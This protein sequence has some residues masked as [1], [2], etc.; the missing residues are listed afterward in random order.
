MAEGYIPVSQSEDSRINL[1]ETDLVNRDPKS[2]NT[3]LQILYDD[4]IGEPEGAHSADC[5]WT[6]AF[7]CFT[8]GKRLCYMILTYVCAIPMALWWGC[9]FACI[10]FT[11]IWHI[12][13]CYKIVK[14]NMECAQRFYSEFINCCLAPVIQAQALILSKI[15]ITLQS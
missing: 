15:H 3:H 4:V 13:P 2:L 12:T 8:G 10:S 6:W 11:H 5:V 14:I 1:A 9:V 7:K